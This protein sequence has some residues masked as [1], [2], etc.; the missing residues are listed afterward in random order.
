M[1]Q[2]L[3]KSNEEINLMAEKYGIEIVEGSAVYDSNNR[4]IS[5]QLANGSYDFFVYE[6]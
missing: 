3:A 5:V 2:V 1:E 6:D 4:L